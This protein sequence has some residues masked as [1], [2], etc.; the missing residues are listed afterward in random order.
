MPRQF[1]NYPYEMCPH[2]VLHKIHPIPVPRPAIR[3][4]PNTIGIQNRE[5][6]ELVGIAKNL[7]EKGCMVILKN[8][9]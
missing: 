5:D 9:F 4:D 1:A 7:M 2:P 6:V 8:Y 3:P